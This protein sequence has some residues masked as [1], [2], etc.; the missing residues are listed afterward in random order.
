M[1]GEFEARLADICDGPWRDQSALARKTLPSMTAKKADRCFRDHRAATIEDP[2]EIEFRESFDQALEELQILELSVCSGYLPLDAV[3][4]HATSEFKTLLAHAAARR[5][6]KIYDFVPVRFLAARLGIDIGDTAVTPPP[7][8]A[9]AGLRFATFLAIHSE[10]VASPAIETFTEL[11]DD[12]LFYDLINAQYFLSHQ[13]I[14]SSQL[15]SDQQRLLEKAA[16]GS[17]EFL[18]LLGDLFLQL[19]TEE[20]PLYGCMYAYWLSHFFGLRRGQ[21]GY[22]QRGVTFEKLDARA[23]LSAVG[24]ASDAE[25]ARLTERMATLRD[26]WNA[27]RQLV[28]SVS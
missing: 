17:V 9:K 22:E 6:L 11:L 26:V 28:E 12:Y 13:G 27:T 24:D 5:Y 1:N 18:Q 15:T 8:N 4:Q 7:I 14:P 19:E 16:I 23:V 21:T 3:R 10:F 20:R 25:Q 2:D